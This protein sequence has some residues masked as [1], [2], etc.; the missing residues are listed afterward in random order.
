[1]LSIEW[2]GSNY[3]KVNA[4]KFQ[5]MLLNTKQEDITIKIKTTEIKSTSQIKL[6]GVN[7]DSKLS[8]D[9][10]INEIVMKASRQINVLCRFSRILNEACKL[11]ILDAF[12]MSNLNYCNL[13]Y[14]HCKLGDAR[15]LEMLLRRALKFVYLDYTSSYKELLC[16][17]DRSCLY[18]NRLRNMLLT[19][20]KILHGNC[21][22][23]NNDFFKVQEMHYNLRCSNMLVKPSYNTKRHGFNSL[24][25]QGA[26]IW[27][28]ISDDVKNLDFNSFRNFVMKWEPECKCGSCLLCTL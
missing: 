27:N 26:F 12:V 5:F 8:Y 21:P 25:Y 15:K 14:H 20:Y 18:V 24:R 17:A 23:I 19:V 28:G 3:M 1:M 10:H 11:R 4:E 22:P 13:A 6:L 2:F 7:F 9:G 16:K